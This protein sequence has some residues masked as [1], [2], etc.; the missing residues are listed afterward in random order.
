MMNPMIFAKGCW[1]DVEALR[2]KYFEV[3]Y[4]YTGKEA[5]KREIQT[6]VIDSAKKP[7]TNRIAK[8]S[9]PINAQNG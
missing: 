1:R 2:D 3:V 5:P 6:K 4:R 9:T 8:Q 7:A